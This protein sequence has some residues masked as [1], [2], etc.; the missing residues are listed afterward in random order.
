MSL[1]RNGFIGKQ[2]VKGLSLMSFMDIHHLDFPKINSWFEPPGSCL[3][4]LNY[5]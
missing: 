3:N 4:I 1:N 5:V 2:V